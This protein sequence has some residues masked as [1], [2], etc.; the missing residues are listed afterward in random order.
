[1]RDSILALNS[2]T[3]TDGIEF[4]FFRFDF[5]MVDKL[6][7]LKDFH[8]QKSTWS[9]LSEWRFAVLIAMA[10]P[11]GVFLE[12]WGQLDLGRKCT[13]GRL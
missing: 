11:F 12:V 9:N 7:T 4:N 6:E 1:M 3:G 2:F 10:N 5:W 8:M 13:T